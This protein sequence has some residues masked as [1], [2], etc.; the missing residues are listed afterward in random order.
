MKAGAQFEVQTV[1]KEELGRLLSQRDYHHS[2]A[3]GGIDVTSGLWWFSG[4]SKDKHHE[5]C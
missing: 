1:L 2:P 4:N 5:I 3:A